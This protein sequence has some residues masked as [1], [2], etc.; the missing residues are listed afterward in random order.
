MHRS[1]ARIG[2]RICTRAIAGLAAVLSMAG[3][4]QAV[5]AG[6]RTALERV[7]PT[8]RTQIR[9]NAAQL[10]AMDATQR[11]ALQRRLAAWQA[12]PAPERRELRMRWQAWQ[13]LPDTERETIRTAATA[14]A[15]LPDAERLALRARFDA[16]DGSDRHGWLLGSTLGVD[17]PR[18]QP[19]L[20]QVPADERL[21]LL[22]VLRSMDATQRLDLSV[23][24]Q[25]T[26]PSQRAALRRELLQVAPASRRAWLQARLDR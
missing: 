17:Y 1:D 22:R 13:A 18:L 14:Y 5:P 21:G 7:P 4:A 2:G 16:L 24:A 12:L 8:Q 20:A 23:L 11:A 25:R 19:L 6:L 3:L 15:A 9:D 10:A 26:P